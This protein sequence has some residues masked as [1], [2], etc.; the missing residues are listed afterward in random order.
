[1][2]G[3]TAD[4]TLEGMVTWVTEGSS[5][6]KRGETVCNDWERNSRAAQD[7]YEYEHCL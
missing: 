2:P 6:F 1:M 4:S 3:A 7:E 5:P